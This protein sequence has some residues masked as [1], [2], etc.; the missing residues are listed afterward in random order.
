MRTRHRLRVQSRVFLSLTHFLFLS[1]SLSL[2][3]SV[4]TNKPEEIEHPHGKPRNAAQWKFIGL[5]VRKQRSRSRDRA[6]MAVR[7]LQNTSTIFFVTE[8]LDRNCQKHCG[9]N[10]WFGIWIKWYCN[11]LIFHIIR[12]FILRCFSI[13]A[14]CMI[15]VKNRRYNKYIYF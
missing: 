7:T 1:F 6:T 9:F 12:D 3:S 8:I 14:R 15:S 11:Y 4:P 13:F 5:I 2:G 10:S